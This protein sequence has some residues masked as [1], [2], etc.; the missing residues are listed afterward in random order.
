M[1]LLKSTIGRKQM[2][3]VAGL[4][5]S[6]FVLMHM[7]GNLLIFIS[8]KVYNE[9]GH[10]IV[11]NPLLYAAEVG[12]VVFFLVHVVLALILTIKNFAARDHR[13]A[14]ASSGAKATSLNTKTLWIQGILIF[15]FVILHLITFKYGAVYHIDYGKGEIRDLFRLMVEVFAQ[16]GYVFWYIFCVL[17]LGFHLIHGLASSFQTMGLNHPRFQPIIKKISLVYGV[18]VA[19]G[20][21]SQ[22]IYMFF[23]FKG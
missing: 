8:P 16:P 4:A 5:L 18:V 22:P 7:L 21:I 14:M 15:I 6:G 12:L 11:S 1:N 9:Y 17:L 13:Y 3:G 10:A 23:F 19:A 2:I 20:F